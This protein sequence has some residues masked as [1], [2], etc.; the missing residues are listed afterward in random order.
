[1]RGIQSK[2][3]IT[4]DPILKRCSG[5]T[6]GPNAVYEVTIGG[7]ATEPRV[8]QPPSRMLYVPVHYKLHWKFVVHLQRAVFADKHSYFAIS[9]WLKFNEE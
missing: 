5:Q 2:S 6:Y 3:K 1:M 9:Q 8:P 4:N 7:I